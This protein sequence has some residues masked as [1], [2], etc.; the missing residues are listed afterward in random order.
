MREAGN[1]MRIYGIRFH[2]I[3]FTTGDETRPNAF[4]AASFNRTR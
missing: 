3:G 2:K 1:G 4:I